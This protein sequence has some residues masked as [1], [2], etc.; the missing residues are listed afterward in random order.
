[1]DDTSEEAEVSTCFVATRSQPM[2]EIV[3]SALSLAVTWTGMVPSRGGRGNARRA[4]SP[5]PAFGPGRSPGICRAW[6]IQRSLLI[7]AA[8]LDE[9]IPFAVEIDRSQ[10]QHRLRP[11]SLPSHSGQLHSIL[12]QVPTGSLRDATADRITRCQVLVVTHVVTVV[13]EIRDS[14]RSRFS[15]FHHVNRFASRAAADCAERRRLCRS[16]SSA[17]DKW[18]TAWR[19]HSPG[20]GES[21]PRPRCATHMHWLRQRR[22]GGIDFLS[23]TRWPKE[24]LTHSRCCHSS[25]T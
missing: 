3:T 4:T 24:S 13:L 16:R 9:L 5:A 8:E 14:R 2:G 7:F 11:N 6:S 10:V 1:M 22:Q 12:D 21:E 15:A 25:R 17:G 23:S 18:R 20:C 19:P